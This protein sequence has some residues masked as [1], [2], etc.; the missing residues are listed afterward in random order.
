MK[1]QEWKVARVASCLLIGFF[2][3]GIL[4]PPHVLSQTGTPALPQPGKRFAQKTDVWGV[5]YTVTIKGNGVD[6]GEPGSGEPGASW[7]I[8]RI[9]HG[10]IMLLDGLV[11]SD[12]KWT[13]K[14]YD[15][16]MLS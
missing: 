9:Y 5:A 11:M 8:S 16:F 4:H 10:N 14:E 3:M 15:D 1:N 2:I 13:L 7:S 12:P 6:E